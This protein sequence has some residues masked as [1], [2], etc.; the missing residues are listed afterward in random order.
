MPRY[1]ALDTEVSLIL[2]EPSRGRPATKEN[3]HYKHINDPW[4][5]QHIEQLREEYF[6]KPGGIDFLGPSSFPFYLINAGQNLFVD[7]GPTPVGDTTGSLGKLPRASTPHPTTEILDE[8]TDSPLSDPPSTV[9][10]SM[11]LGGPINTDTPKEEDSVKVTPRKKGLGKDSDDNDPKTPMSEPK[12]WLAR[13][14]VT[15]ASCGGKYI[16]KPITKVIPIKVQ[17][18]LDRESFIMSLIDHKHSD[19]C[20]NIFYNGQL[21]HSR[22]LGYQTVRPSGADGKQISFSGRRVGCSIEVPFVL[23][24]LSEIHQNSSGNGL[25]FQERWNRTNRLLLKEAEK[26]GRSGKYGMFRS[27]VGEYLEELSRLCVPDCIKGEKGNHAGIIDV[28]CPL[29]AFVLFSR[30]H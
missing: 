9:T 14:P 24:P 6:D 10:S 1:N 30:C 4:T 16:S 18:D 2:W 23:L 15:P 22:V 28:S 7:S 8:D 3:A 29:A 13:H 5:G 12:G 27:P 21:T 11:S 25:H 17:L 26:W 20:V 19:L